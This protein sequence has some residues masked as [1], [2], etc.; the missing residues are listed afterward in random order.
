MMV[1]RPTNALLPVH[2]VSITNQEFLNMKSP[3]SNV[4]V[5]IVESP[6]KRKVM[7]ISVD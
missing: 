1:E 7:A 3:V 2:M 4:T 6:A 5:T